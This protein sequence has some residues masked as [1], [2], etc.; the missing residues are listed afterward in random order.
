MQLRRLERRRRK[1]RL[2]AGERLPEDDADG[3]DVGR[4]CRFV[5]RQPL[6]G[7]VGERPG[8]IAGRRQRV[9]VVEQRQPEVEQPYRHLAA[10][11]EQQVRRLD[12]PVHDSSPV[13]VGKRVE[14]LRGGLDGAPVV[15]HPV[16]DRLAQRAARNVL[17]RD[18]HVSL[19]AVDGEYAGAI[20]VAEP[21]HGNR[22][23]LGAG[24]RLALLRDDLER[25]VP[26]LSFV[27]GEPHRAGATAP[28]RAQRPIAAEDELVLGARCGLAH[29]LRADLAA[30]LRSPARRSAG[31]GEAPAGFAA[32]LDRFWD[33]P[34]PSLAARSERGEGKPSP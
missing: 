21:G 13:R 3:P 34:K 16:P 4:T 17:V 29:R 7:D 5:A 8:D 10:L 1:E 22:L 23:P 25:D 6:G 20:P 30:T 14:H 9:G 15:E 12:V 11:D 24:A 27:P 26:T 19:V 18:V 28:E 32:M 2:L 33:G 31:N